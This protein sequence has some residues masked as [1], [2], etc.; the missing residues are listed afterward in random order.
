MVKS[1]LIDLMKNS[2]LTPRDVAKLLGVDRFRIYAWVRDGQ[3]PYLRTVGRILFDPEE[4][5]QWLRRDRDN[6]SSLSP[7]VGANIEL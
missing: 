5:D 1:H 3:I 2:Y 7:E 4:I 6:N